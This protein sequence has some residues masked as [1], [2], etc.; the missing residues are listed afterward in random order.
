MPEKR[1]NK[2]ALTALFIRFTVDDNNSISYKTFSRD[3]C[4][5]GICLLSP[6]RLKLNDNLQLNIDIPNNP[7]MTL[8]E[9]NV[10]WTSQKSMINEDGKE[11]FPAGVA[12]TY[13]E[14][15]DKAFLS[16][17]IGKKEKV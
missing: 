8:A 10:R 4:V 6:K 12:F 16:E 5:D 2:R 17:F 3:M 9:G 1:Q 15:R 7:D 14:S 11:V 13:L